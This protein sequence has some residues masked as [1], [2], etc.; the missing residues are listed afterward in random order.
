M[1]Q[2]PTDTH[3]HNPHSRDAVIQLSP[4]DE[5]ATD[6]RLYSIGIHPWDTTAT[7]I[8]WET[9]LNT[10]ADTATDP[11]IVM[12]GE[13]GIDTVRGG[14]IDLQLQLLRRQIDISEHVGKP[15][16]LHVV[17]AWPQVTALRR[18]LHPAQLWIAHGFR[19]NPQLANELLRTGIDISL[20]EKFN[21]A[22]AAIIPPDRLHIET[23]TSTTDIAIIANRIAEARAAMCKKV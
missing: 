17:H 2:L 12:I 15:L 6:G 20:G 14:A 19:G 4:G 7:N 21:P 16:L 5:M 9:L 1:T 3:T 22:T 10:I 11:R 23:D 18:S 13:A 8:D